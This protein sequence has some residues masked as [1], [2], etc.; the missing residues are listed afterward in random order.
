MRKSKQERTA[1]VISRLRTMPQRPFYWS[2]LSLC[3][4]HRSVSSTARMLLAL[5]DRGG[6]Q[7]ATFHTLRTYLTPA[8]KLLQRWL[9]SAPNLSPPPPI[10]LE[11][12]EWL[13]LQKT[14]DSN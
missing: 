4:G 11:A 13:K 3:S 1:W 12:Q 2:I 14:T 5:P 8:N 6:L 7:T 10:F 9:E